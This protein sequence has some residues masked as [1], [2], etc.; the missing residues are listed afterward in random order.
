MEALKTIWTLPVFTFGDGV[1]VRVSQLFL[2]ALVLLGGYVL[3]KVIERLIRRRLA[4]TEIR[5]DA[6]LLMQ[7]F[8]YYGLLTA[9]VMTALS[10]LHVPLGAFAFISGAVAI[11]VGFGAQNIVN[12]FISGWILL[13]ERPVRVN[14][15]VEID[16][17]QGVVENIG[18]RSTRIRRVDGVHL[19]I[20]NS[21]MLERTV[22]N[23]TLVDD[24][25][26]TVL[27]VGVAYG[28][29]LRRV[30]ELIEQAVREQPDVIPDPPPIV[31][32][33]DFGDSAILFE[34]YL[35]SEVGG[36]RELRQIRS[37]IRF[38]IDELFSE[39]G[40]VIAFPQLDVHLNSVA[41]IQMPALK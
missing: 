28:S 33:D 31:V 3:S 2:V 5:P 4:Q 22:V 23:W 39:H 9:V 10:L 38:R 14:D 20:P 18:N 25:I 26:R 34:A 11:G 32:C 13:V 30:A 35:W 8:V 41:P 19:L 6:A 17:Y 29:P 27:K 7:R 36:E 1:S 40:I 12:N 21:Q 15:F 37:N 16:S 24:R